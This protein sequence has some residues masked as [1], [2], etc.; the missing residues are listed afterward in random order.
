MNSSDPAIEDLEPDGI[1]PKC[2]GPMFETEQGLEC[3]DHSCNKK[4]FI[5]E[6]NRSIFDE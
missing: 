5:K 3:V 2:G 4:L 1:C 6:E